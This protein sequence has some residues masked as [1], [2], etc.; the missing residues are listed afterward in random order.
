MCA[1]RVVRARRRTCLA[2]HGRAP[3]P[4]RRSP[5][6][7]LEV[8]EPEAEPSRRRHRRLIFRDL[9]VSPS[10]TFVHEEPHALRRDVVPL[11]SSGR[12]RSRAA[13]VAIRAID[14]SARVSA[15]PKTLIVVDHSV[16][17]FCYLVA[18]IS[19]GYRVPYLKWDILHALWLSVFS[20][21]S[22]CV[23]PGRCLFGF[24]HEPTPDRTSLRLVRVP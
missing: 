19:S 4:R 1:S 5:G 9:A 15:K 22:C 24:D 20:T 18:I 8:V 23:L 14:R 11:P 7:P 21:N 17:C 13:S 12:H 6:Q 3:R 10:G 16:V 2:P